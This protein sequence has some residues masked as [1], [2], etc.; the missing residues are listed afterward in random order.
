MLQMVQEFILKVV[1]ITPLL[2]KMLGLKVA[3]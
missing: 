3:E 1:Q 2:M